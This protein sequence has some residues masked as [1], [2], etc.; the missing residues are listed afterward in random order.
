MV[1]P[2]LT[3]AI[4]CLVQV[5]VVAHYSRHG[6]SV[7]DGRDTSS[8]RSKRRG[9]G[10]PVVVVPTPNAVVLLGVVDRRRNH[11]QRSEAVLKNLETKRFLKSKRFLTNVSLALSIMTSISRI[12]DDASHQ[13]RCI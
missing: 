13:L 5:N 3:A 8:R 2:L 10:G 11:K 6:K 1:R 7:T 12:L 9:R 4:R